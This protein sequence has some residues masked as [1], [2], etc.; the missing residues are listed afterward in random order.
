[1]QPDGD[2]GL[3]V[4]FRVRR[5]IRVESSSMW[6]KYAAKRAAIQAKRDSGS[7]QNF[8][9]PV[10]TDAT[11][12]KHKDLFAPLANEINEIYAFHG[13][14]VRAALSIAQH[15]FNID[16]AG[17]S[18]GT[19]YGRGAY[20]GESITKADE[21]AKDEPGGYYA[22]VFAVL[23]CRVCMGMLY[24]TSDNPEAASK[25]AAG[26]FDSTCG[27][28][29]FRELVIYDADQLYPEYLVLY[30]RV[31]KDDLDAEIEKILAQCFF[32][33][34][35]LHWKNNANDL[36]DGFCEQCPVS[37]ACREFLQCLVEFSGS[38]QIVMSCNRLENSQLWQRY[39]H[40]KADLCCRLGGRDG[41]SAIGDCDPVTPTLGLVEQDLRELTRR[42]CKF[43]A[44]SGQ[45]K[46][47][48][49]CRFSHNTVGAKLNAL[50]LA[51][52]RRLPVDEL[53]AQLNE[54]FLWHPCSKESAIDMAEG[55]LNSC[56]GSLGVGTYFYESLVTA[57]GHVESDDGTTFVFLCRV[58]CGVPSNGENESDCSIGMG[59]ACAIRRIRPEV[60]VCRPCQ[61]YPEFSFELQSAEEPV[62]FENAVLEGD[63]SRSETAASE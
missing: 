57:L 41:R 30:Q 12:Q 46:F 43:F 40:F 19:L 56:D 26:D 3:P 21:Y 58:V 7:V 15:D 6:A 17:S 60:V 45:C 2:P 52:G 5:V 20:M 28:R 47:G 49:K 27:T 53:D 4:G 34:V 1:M 37:F 36:K 13:T 50:G 51:A 9:P 31:Y 25:I 42:P 18:R 63:S 55:I 16:L 33:E 11:V 44:K 38:S 61:V 24:R 10:L 32:M 23:V 62:Q 54:M 39:V 8:D 29:L 14:C 59:S 22:S 48:D 35:P